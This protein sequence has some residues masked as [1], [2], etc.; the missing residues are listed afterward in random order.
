[1]T[2]ETLW[3]LIPLF[4]LLGAALNLFFGWRWSGTVAG[5]LGAAMVG[6]SALLTLWGFVAM[7]PIAP[8]E[9]HL[10]LTLWSWLTTGSFNVDVSF[11]IDP[12]SM[13]M[14]SVI[15]GVGFLI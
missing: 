2:T 7:I 11:L 14:M 9:R 4:P 1:M 5:W 10:T 12:L 8:N 6:L 3:T 15:T 13:M